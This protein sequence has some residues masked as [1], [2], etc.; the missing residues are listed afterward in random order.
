MIQSKYYHRQNYSYSYPPGPNQNHKQ[1]ICF[2]SLLTTSVWAPRARAMFLQTRQYVVCFI[3]NFDKSDSNSSLPCPETFKHNTFLKRVVLKGLWQPSSR[4][5]LFYNV[6]LILL[7]QVH[8]CY[9]GA[10]P[11]IISI[12]II[13]IIIIS[14][15]LRIDFVV[16]PI[17]RVRINDFQS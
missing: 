16:K 4:H 11:I 5:L 6:F 3:S 8:R 2:I 14:I 9:D 10:R 17:R 13:I 15:G 1:F 7:L 12:I